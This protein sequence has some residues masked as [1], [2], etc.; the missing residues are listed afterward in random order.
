[1]YYELVER[2]IFDLVI[3]I[4]VFIT[5]PFLVEEVLSTAYILVAQVWRILYCQ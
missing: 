4:E 1:M 2:L 3:G 5:Q